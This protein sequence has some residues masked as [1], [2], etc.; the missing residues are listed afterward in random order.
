MGAGS[1]GLSSRAARGGVV[2]AASFNVRF[3]V[4]PEGRSCLNLGEEVRPSDPDFARAD[5]EAYEAAVQRISRIDGEALLAALRH[6]RVQLLPRGGYLLRA[7]QSATEVAVVVTGLLREHFVMK[8]G[9][10]RTKAFVAEREMTGS[11]ADL[12]SGG[13]SK[14]FIVAEE[15]SRLLVSS[16]DAM[17]TLARQYPAWRAFGTRVL[18]RLLVTKAERE[19]ELLGLSAEERY[20]A[21]SDRYPGLEARVV[22]K[23]VASYLGITPVHLSRL[24]RRRARGKPAEG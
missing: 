8:D 4:P 3:N 11:L 23:H 15:P 13:P 9:A 20:R 19:Y 16:Y 18:E 12:L 2:P 6:V 1:W 10:E 22:G 21:F 7:G 17:Q 24:R 14:A 5:R